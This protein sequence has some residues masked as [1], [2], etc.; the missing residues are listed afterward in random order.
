[1]VFSIQNSIT[2]ARHVN[3]LHTF[4]KSMNVLLEIPTLKQQWLENIVHTF[5]RFLA[6][7]FKYSPYLACTW[8]SNQHKTKTWNSNSFH[9]AE[10]RILDAWV[11][12]KYTDCETNPLNMT[13]HIGTVQDFFQKG[14]VWN[15]SPRNLLTRTLRG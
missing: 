10:C 14:P 9:T 3:Y 6:S 11:Y 5:F 13:L 12:Y 7:L 4:N 1:M 15:K 8:D 2:F